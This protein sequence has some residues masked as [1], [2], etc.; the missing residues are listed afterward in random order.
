MKRLNVFI[1]T[2]DRLNLTRLCIESIHQ[3]TEHFDE[4]HVY[5]SDTMSSQTIKARRDMF[6]QF[7]EK[8]YIV[9]YTYS[10]IESDSHCFTK[11]INFNK[12]LQN[13]ELKRIV[14]SNFDVDLTNYYVLLDND[15]IVKKNWLGPYM[16]VWEEM[17]PKTP[18][19]Q[20]LCQ[21]PGGCSVRSGTPV[22]V[23]DKTEEKNP[24]EVFLSGGGGSGFWF[25]G[26]RSLKTLQWRPHDYKLVKFVAN[27]DDTTTWKKLREEYGGGYSASVKMKNPRVMHMGKVFGSIVNALRQKNYAEENYVN[28]DNELANTTVDQLISKYGGDGRVLVW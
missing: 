3:N 15:M 8:K 23:Q 7:L 26:E 14:D 2:R 13:M 9:N 21:H 27:S 18:A 24:C 25:F 12:W 22:I 20:Y 10:T 16:S 1:T 5:I 11:A 6:Q 4:V 19:L 28:V 17:S